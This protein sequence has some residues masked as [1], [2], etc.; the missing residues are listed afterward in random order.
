MRHFLVIFKQYNFFVYKL[1]L[2]QVM[3]EMGKYIQ[4]R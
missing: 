2:K 4:R 1:V 3:M